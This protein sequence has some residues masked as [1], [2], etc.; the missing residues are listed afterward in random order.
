MLNLSEAPSWRVQTAEP[1]LTL[2]L[3][4]AQEAAPH[5][6]LPGEPTWR[7]LGSLGGR[8]GRLSRARAPPSK[9]GATRGLGDWRRLP[10][11]PAPPPRPRRQGR[12]GT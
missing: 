2:E 12:L 11:P 7:R 8:R 10:R 4:T 3:P 5:G 1:S 9:G 6:Q